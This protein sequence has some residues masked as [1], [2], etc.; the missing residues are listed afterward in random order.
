MAGGMEHTPTADLYSS[1][2]M[3]MIIMA[4]PNGRMGIFLNRLKKFS[5]EGA[6]II[7]WLLILS[8][9]FIFIFLSS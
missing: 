9:I 3:K 6:R 5:L 4:T 2:I 1:R 8:S 7:L